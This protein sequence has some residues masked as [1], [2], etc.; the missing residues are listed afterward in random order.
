[1]NSLR[2]LRVLAM[3]EA[4]S[5]TGTAK[6]VLEFGYEAS[7]RDAN[8]PHVQL[9]VVNFARRSVP[10]RHALTTALENASI[11]LHIVQERG[12][13]D[14]AVI[15]QLRR[16]ISRESP[17]IVWS[18]SVK[19]HFL[20]RA[21]KLHHGRKWIAFHH[22]YTTTDW[23]VRLYNQLDRWS[24]GGAD[25]VITVCQPFADQIRK[26]GVDAS[27]IRVQHMPIR[28]FAPSEA[29]C[30]R[31]RLEL[32]LRA[33]SAIILSVGRLSREKGHGDLIRAFARIRRASGSDSL[34]LILV[35]DGP[36]RRRLERICD[37]NQL[38]NSVIFTGHR[39]DAKVFYGIADVFVLPS[40]TEGSPNVLLEAMAAKVPIVATNVGGV[41]ELATDGEN[42]IL[43]NAGDIPAIAGAISRLLSD[44]N[45]R[46][47]FTSSAPEVVM[48]HSPEAYFRSLVSVFE[49]TLID[50]S[51][52]DRAA[53][54]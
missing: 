39:N 50:T 9:S 43:V 31:L 17:D 53:G 41:P 4:N 10:A 37:S 33:D 36:E 34:R 22:G 46:E 21:A 35:G 15:A 44:L 8:L 6:A 27:R 20:V 7:R 38:D 42:A 51:T 14:R 52:L 13:F 45:L 1:M 12:R 11:P 47:R 29:E 3:V 49:E 23:K 16:V 48:R 28:P 18:N 2:S 40:Y 19:S 24:L 54:L 30:G 26:R 5:I 32:A 25:R